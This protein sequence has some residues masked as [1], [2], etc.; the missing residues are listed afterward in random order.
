MRVFTREQF[1]ELVWAKP[2]TTL[3]KEFLLSDVALH[4]VC[5]KHD[6]P[7]PPPGWWAKKQAGKKV[8]VSKLP[9]LKAGISHANGETVASI[10]G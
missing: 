10:T 1:H 4:K 3:A 6:V 7:T 5:R 9:R 8:A 2:M